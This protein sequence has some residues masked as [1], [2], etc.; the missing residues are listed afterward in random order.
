MTKVYVVVDACSGEDYSVDDP[1]VLLVTT[2][3]AKAKQFFEDEISNW[4]DGMTNFDSDRQ[5]YKDGKIVYE[6]TDFD[7]DSHRI[8]KLVKTIVE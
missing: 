8:L 3:K 6:C 2:D 5:I 7:G 1:T 4:E